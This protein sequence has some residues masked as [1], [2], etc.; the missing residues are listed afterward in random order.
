MTVQLPKTI[1]QWFTPEQACKYLSDAFECEVLESD[2]NIFIIEHRI[3]VFY[4]TFI[5]KELYFICETDLVFHNAW[6]SKFNECF[7]QKNQTSDY[8]YLT[9]T[10]E[11][12]EYEVVLSQFDSLSIESLLKNKKID[13]HICIIDGK[14]S[15]KVA[16]IHYYDPDLPSFPR[17]V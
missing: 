7:S 11:K 2:L 4:K 12:G 10:L 17:T 13:K 8:I 5:A 15:N 1:R 3:G 14:E 16:D 9:Y 6:F